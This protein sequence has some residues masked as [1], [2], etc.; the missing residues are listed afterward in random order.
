MRRYLIVLLC[1]DLGSRLAGVVKRFAIRRRTLG[2]N[3]CAWRECWSVV[4]GFDQDR[5][6][7]LRV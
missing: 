6:G 2:R 4:Q 1:V 5:V 7:G 3:A